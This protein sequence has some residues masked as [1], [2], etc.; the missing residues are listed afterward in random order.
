MF[1]STEKAGGRREG[2]RETEKDRERRKMDRDIEKRGRKREK[3]GEGG[4]GGRE[5]PKTGGEFS[6]FLPVYLQH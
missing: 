1:T 2:W 3:K 5:L 6:F 4:E